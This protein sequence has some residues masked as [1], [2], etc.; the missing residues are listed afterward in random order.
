MTRS[1]FEDEHDILRLSHKYAVA[2]D[3]GNADLL[4]EVFWEDSS[5]STSELAGSRGHKEILQLPAR[6]AAAFSQT[7]HAIQPQHCEVSDT[8]AVGVTYCFAYHFTKQDFITPGRGTIDLSYNQMIRYDDRYEFRSGEWKILTRHL[9]VMFRRLEPVLPYALA[10][11][12]APEA[13]VPEAESLL[14]K[15]QRSR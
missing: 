14:P 2:L 4:R 12:P 9:N 7:H 5:W 10:D 8:S 11:R 3:T 6:L 1:R 15:E 13:S